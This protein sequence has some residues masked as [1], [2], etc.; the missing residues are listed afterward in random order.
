M[1]SL[2]LATT[3]E[4]CN[5]ML[6]WDSLFFNFW[7]IAGPNDVPFSFLTMVKCALTHL[8]QLTQSNVDFSIIFKLLTM[9]FTFVCLLSNSFSDFKWNAV[10]NT[11]QGEPRNFEELG[12]NFKWTM[13]KILHSK[14]CEIL[15]KM[16]L[17]GDY[18]AFNFILTASHGFIF[19]KYS[20]F[21]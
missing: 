20:L 15:L 19:K 7:S 5:T 3:W 12:N 17:R 8:Y 10:L 4:A 16:V 14:I 18:I 13:T 11:M 1:G 21:L 2:I 9:G 6:S